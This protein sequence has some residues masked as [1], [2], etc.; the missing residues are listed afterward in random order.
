MPDLYP[1][2]PDQQSVMPDL[3][4][5]LLLHE[6]PGRAGYDE[7]QAGYDEGRAGHDEGVGHKNSPV[8]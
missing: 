8:K 2:M 5:H 7:G 3:F 1:V 4:G 6:I